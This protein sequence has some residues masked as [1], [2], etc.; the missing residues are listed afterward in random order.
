MN[1]I[2]HKLAEDKKL[3]SIYFTAGYPELEDTVPII[4]KL[5]KSGVDMVEIGLPFSDP[6]ADGPVIQQSSTQALKNGMT[7][8]KLFEQL[9]GIRPGG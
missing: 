7:S 3:L 5:E 2:N 4:Q 6:L 8:E 1:R 9:K